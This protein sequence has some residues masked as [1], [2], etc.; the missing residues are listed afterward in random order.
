MSG[1]SATLRLHRDL[2]AEAA[3]RDAVDTFAGF[4][5]FAVAR[6]GDHFVVELTEID[7]DADGDVAAELANF[8]L[9]NSA[10]LRKNDHA[11]S[12]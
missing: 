6:E 9:A 5:D 12:E 10:V 11:R 2:Y 7:A 3:I 4:A 8:A 1:G